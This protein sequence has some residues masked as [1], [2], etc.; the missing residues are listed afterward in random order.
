MV[1]SN[2]SASGTVLPYFGTNNLNATINIDGS[3]TSTTLTNTS[4]NRELAALDLMMISPSANATNTV[5]Y[6]RSMQATIPSTNSYSIPQTV[7][8]HTVA[9]NYGTGS[10]TRLTGVSTFAA[11]YGSGTANILMG[12]SFTVATSGAGSNATTAYGVQS[13]AANSGTM[14]NAYGVYVTGYGAATGTWTNTPYDI[15]AAD[16][17]AYN[18]FAGNVGIGTT[19]P[20]SKLS[21]SSN[22]AALPAVPASTSLHLGGSDGAGPQV[23]L[24][25]FA[26]TPQIRI[27]RAN[28]TAATPS[29]ILLGDSLGQITWEGYGAS[30]Y[31]TATGAKIVAQAAENW[32]DSTL[33]AVL[34]FYTRPSGVT[35]GSVERMRIDQNGNVGI[36]V[37][38]PGQRLQ[39]GS[40][41]DSSVAIANAWNTFSDI[42][43][44][45][46]IERIPNA[47]EMVDQLNGYYYYWKDGEDRSRQV[48]V[49]AQEVEK[50]LPELVKTGSDGIKTVDYPKLTAILIEASKQHNRDIAAVKAEKADKAV[51]DAELRSLESE[52]AQLKQENAEIKARLERIEKILQ[53][54]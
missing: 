47:C 12:G 11:N 49:I 53:S 36:G 10:V 16:S 29:A 17:T 23:I 8:A 41:G 45:K 22:S 18:Y 37:T 54:K 30:S 4:T 24:D 42:R 14:T 9:A 46:G 40:S 31:N 25:A 48:G 52:N 38:N 26:N 51:V 13:V 21:I 27:R 2:T 44:K 19:S 7:A 3:Y 34:G 6:G 5:I 33:A 32:T 39:V 28:T 50:I 35:T 20:D 15:Y 43:L 1:V